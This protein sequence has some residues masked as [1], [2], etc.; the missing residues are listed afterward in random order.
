[1]TSK[2]TPQIRLSRWRH[3]VSASPEGRGVTHNGA[4]RWHQTG[5]QVLSEGPA[6]ATPT[7][8]S[9]QR[10]NYMRRT[11]KSWGE[12]YP[13]KENLKTPIW[14]NNRYESTSPHYQIHSHPVHVF[15]PFSVIPSVIFG[16]VNSEA[17]SHKV[18]LGV[19]GSGHHEV[20]F[21]RDV[22]TP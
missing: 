6:V 2:H 11:L 10:A 18:S 20:G 17:P 22:S 16:R 4:R 21:F 19:A 14:F 5:T 1:M 8:T 7:S 12:W 9:T 15:S 13:F 3:G